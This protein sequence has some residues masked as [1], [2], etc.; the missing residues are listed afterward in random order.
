MR[1]AIIV[2]VCFWSLLGPLSA[3]YAAGWNGF[4]L[5]AETNAGSWWYVRD[6]YGVHTQMF[7]AVNERLFVGTPQE[8]LG[9]FTFTQPF[10]AAAGS[11]QVTGVFTSAVG[12]IGYTNTILATCTITQRLAF[13]Y[14]TSTCPNEIEYVYTNDAGTFTSTAPVWI[15]GGIYNQENGSSLSFINALSYLLWRNWNDATDEYVT[16]E[17]YILTNAMQGTVNYDVYF[18]ATNADGSY[19]DSFPRVGKVGLFG[20]NGIGITRNGVTNDQGFVALTNTLATNYA[21][22]TVYPAAVQ[23]V[24][25]GELHCL[26]NTNWTFVDVGHFLP[27][28]QDAANTRALYFEDGLPVITNSDTN[29]TGAVTVTGTR[30]EQETFAGV[31]TPDQTISNASETLTAGVVNDQSAYFWN[32]ITNITATWSG[33]VGQV[34]AMTYTGSVGFYGQNY[35]AGW[36]CRQHWDEMQDCVNALRHTIEDSGWVGKGEYLR[37]YAQGT[38]GT[39]WAEAKLNAEAVWS[40]AP[41]TSA[42][43][44]APFRGTWGTYNGAVTQWV[45]GIDTAKAYATMSCFTPIQAVGLSHRTTQSSNLAHSAVWYMAADMYADGTYSNQT[46]DGL[47]DGLAVQNRYEWQGTMTPLHSL[48]TTSSVKYGNIA[49]PSTWCAEPDAT[50]STSRGYQLKSIGYNDWAIS[51]GFQFQ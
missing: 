31:D 7:H 5:Q 9:V 37:V 34:V 16:G 32:D 18:A 33:S 29:R 27:E 41:Q 36:M 47:G 20:H 6:T 10:S 3:A 35:D 8:G 42:V 1:R 17:R 46:F 39:S 14:Y 26:G 19:P 40:N 22:W 21:W 38:S 44:T 12:N 23:P 48:S 49:V 45:A 51:G 24:T 15:E 11:N 30:F 25:L 28:S 50:N 4:P 2:A 13:G 43:V